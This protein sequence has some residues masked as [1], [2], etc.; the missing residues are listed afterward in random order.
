MTRRSDAKSFLVVYPNYFGKGETI[1]EASKNAKKAGYK[2]PRGKR[3]SRASVYA[4]SCLAEDLTLSA[5][6]A[7]RWSAPDGTMVMRWEMEVQ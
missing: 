6:V 2:H 5:D 3:K 4:F 1:D 7:V